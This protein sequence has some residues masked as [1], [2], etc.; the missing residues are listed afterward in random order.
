MNKSDIQRI[1]REIGEQALDSNPD[2]ISAATIQESFINIYGG[3]IDALTEEVWNDYC[4]SKAREAFENLKTTT[5]DPQMRLKLEGLPEM[6]P[7]VTTRAD[8]GS[9]RLKR[10]EFAT[11]KDLLHD[12]DVHETN[13]KAAVKKRDMAIERNDAVIPVMHDRDLETVGEVLQ[14]LAQAAA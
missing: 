11:E 6:E 13:V 4:R 10:V 2:G 3:H 14:A 1:M 9:D 7:T 8:D 5:N 12:L